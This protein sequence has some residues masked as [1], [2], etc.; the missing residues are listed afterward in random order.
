MEQILNNLQHSSLQNI[1]A[2]ISFAGAVASLIAAIARP[3]FQANKGDKVHFIHHFPSQSEN[4]DWSGSIA[5]FFLFT[6]LL[7]LAFLLDPFINPFQFPSPVNQA[8]AIVQQF[9]DDLNN[10]DYQSAYDLTKE[11]FDT[12]YEK[13][14]N[15]YK[16]TEHNDITSEDINKD[17]ST[18]TIDVSVTIKATED[19]PPGKRISYY[20]FLLTIGQDNGTYKI[21]AITPIPGD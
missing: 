1:T 18:N 4:T 12:N 21:L 16:N 10:K 13:F 8:Q 20:A 14:V 5:L 3:F 19:L 9:Y 17:F 15:D 7:L 6:T 2:I 11:E